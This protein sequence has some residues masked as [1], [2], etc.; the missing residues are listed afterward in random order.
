MNTVAIVGVGLIGGSFGLAIRKAGFEGEI[1]GVSSPPAIEAGFRAKA[2]SSTATLEDAAA[3]AELI[4][5]AQPV[6][7]ILQTLGQLGP[8]VSGQCL[9]TDAGSTKAA[10]V[11]EALRC[12]P[13]E[14]FLGGHPLAG[15]E[16]RGV[17]AADP[18]LFRNRPYVLTPTG[19]A[20]PASENFR[21]WL[22]RIGARIID[23]SASDHDA[24]VAFTSHLPQLASSALAAT[25]SRQSN[26]HLRRVFGTGLL[27]MT[28]LAVSSPDLWSS[29]L[30]TNKIQVDR[31]I[32]S[33]IQVLMELKILVQNGDVASFMRTGATFASQLRNTPPG[34][35]K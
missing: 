7:R 27:D 8:L 35:P 22:V 16:Q 23:M 28:R 21:S 10:I 17:D 19:A 29:I 20:S 32:E 31:S 2:I 11:Q 6:D 24:T 5:L 12:L 18:E 25:L 30:D 26:P 15:K 4:Y 1:I 14:T 33:L 9:V 13:S 34:Y 3:R